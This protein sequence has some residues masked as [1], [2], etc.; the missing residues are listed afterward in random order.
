[1]KLSWVLF[2]PTI[3]FL[4]HYLTN[5]CVPACLCVPSM[6]TPMCVCVLSSTSPTPAVIHYTPS[7]LPGLHSRTQIRLSGPVCLALVKTYQHFACRI[8]PLSIILGESEMSGRCQGE[9]SFQDKD[10]FDKQG[11]YPVLSV[12]ISLFVSIISSVEQTITSHWKK[13]SH[14]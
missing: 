10:W 12:C 9:L 3:Y 7:R 1:M 11:I 6:C 14:P 8:F 5:V 4:G 13:L 2:D